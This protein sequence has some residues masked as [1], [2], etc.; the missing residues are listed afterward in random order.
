MHHL[1][2]V[3]AVQPRV[4]REICT[5]C[6]LRPLGSE[7]LPPGTPRPCQQACPIFQLLPLLVIRA[8]RMDPSI[9]CPEHALREMVDQHGET[10]EGADARLLK[11][12][13]RRVANIVSEM[14]DTGAQ[15]VEATE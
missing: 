9:S 11:L 4:R 5:R 12:Y 13:G 8:E 14:V 10:L 7:L 1:L 2:S 6:W 15:R 3:A